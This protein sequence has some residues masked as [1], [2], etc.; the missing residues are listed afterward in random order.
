MSDDINFVQNFN[1]NILNLHQCFLLLDFLEDFMW[2]FLRYTCWKKVGDILR[3]AVVTFFK[4]LRHK[5]DTV[6]LI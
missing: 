1:Q 3:D 2:V 6:A 4:A 5:N